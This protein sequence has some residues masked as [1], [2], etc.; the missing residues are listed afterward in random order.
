MIPFKEDEDK[1]EWCCLLEAVE[2][3]E[4]KTRIFVLKYLVADDAPFCSSG[5]AA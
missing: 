4:D 5:S 2:G 1:G 3:S